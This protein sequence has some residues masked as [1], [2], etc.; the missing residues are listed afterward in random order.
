MIEPESAAFPGPSATPEGERYHSGGHFAKIR[1]ATVHYGLY[2]RE[3]GVFARA[4][5]RC[6]GFTGHR[7]AILWRIIG[8]SGNKNKECFGRR[9]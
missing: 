5:Q 6:S 8:S 3:C 1:T 4:L 2:L 9:G 7:A